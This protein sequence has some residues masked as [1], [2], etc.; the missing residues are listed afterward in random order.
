[1]HNIDYNIYDYMIIRFK[2]VWYSKAQKNAKI[3]V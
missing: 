1:M 3:Y 2:D